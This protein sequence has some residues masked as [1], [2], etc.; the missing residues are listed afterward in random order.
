MQFA[1]WILLACRVRDSMSRRIMR[2]DVR[3]S[4]RTIDAYAG[5]EIKIDPR[6]K[7]EINI[8]IEPTPTRTRIFQA[9]IGG[10]AKDLQC[11]RRS[12]RLTEILTIGRAG[13]FVVAMLA[14]AAQLHRASRGGS[15]NAPHATGHAR[16]T[17]ATAWRGVLRASPAGAGQLVS[18][19]GTASPARMRS[20]FPATSP[21]G[22]PVL[23]T[24][25]AR[26]TLDRFPARGA[27]DGAPWRRRGRRMQRARS[28]V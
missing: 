22:P 19:A 12:H 28:V 18:G 3:R 23:T 17:A 7:I 2:R 26:A 4:A 11:T 9:L 8:D 24:S 16:A 27:G 25:M 21:P 13:S 1:H 20:T 5:V 6:I 14:N 15:K 10:R